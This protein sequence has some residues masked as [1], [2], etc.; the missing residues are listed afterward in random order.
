MSRQA[1]KADFLFK[2]N[3]L[4]WDS[5]SFTKKYKS[6]TESSHISHTQFS[7][8]LTF[9]INMLHVLQIMNQYQYIFNRSPYFIQIS[10]VFTYVSS[11]ISDSSWDDTLH[12][13]VMSVQRHEALLDCDSFSLSLVLMI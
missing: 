1:G 5:F 13:V 12:S 4:V 11:T 7:L 6:S 8:S 2:V 9:Y 10:S 3:F